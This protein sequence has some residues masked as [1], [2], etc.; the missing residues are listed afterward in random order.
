ME[1]DSAAPVSGLSDL[2]AMFFG[3]KIGREEAGPWAALSRDLL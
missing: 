2:E 3:F 1:K